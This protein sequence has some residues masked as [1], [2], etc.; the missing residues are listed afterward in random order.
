MAVLGKRGIQSRGPVNLFRTL[1]TAA[2]ETGAVEAMPD[3]PKAPPPG[4]SC[5]ARIDRRGRRHARESQRMAERGRSVGRACRVEARRG[6][7]V[8]GL[9]GRSR[10]TSPLPPSQGTNG[11]FPSALRSP[12][13]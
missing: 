11:W 1:L 4:R 9:E 7:G 10:K 5:P 13:C 6:E 12:R 2:V 3:F 8:G